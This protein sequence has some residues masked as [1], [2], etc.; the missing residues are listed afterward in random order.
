MPSNSANNKRIAKNTLLLY[1]RMAFLMIVSL[2]TSRVILQALGVEDFGIFNVVGGIISMFTILS[3]SLT[4]AITRFITFE[5]GKNNMERLKSVFATS[6]NIQLGIS[7]LI[8]LIA[9]VIGLWF[10]NHEMNIPAERIEA[11]NV[12]LH[13]SLGI[14]VFNLISVPYN[15][16]IIAHEQMGAYAYI[17]ILDILLKLVV[18]YA[19]NYSPIDCLS[20][21]ALLLLAEAAFIRMVYG[22]YSKRH[23][24]ECTYSFTHD[25]TVLKEM[26]KFAGWNFLG[27][28]AGTLNTQGVNILMNIYFNVSVNAARGIAVQ[29]GA[30]ITQFVHSFTTAVNPQITKSYAAGNSEYLFSLIC[31]SAKFST[32]LFLLIAIPLVVEAPA[33]FGLWLHT[34]PD[35]AVIFFRLSVLGILMDNVLV[36]PLITAIMATGDIKKYQVSVT[37][38]GALVFPL[39]WLSYHIGATPEWTYIIYFIIY[40]LVL[41]IRLRIV[42]EKVGLPIHRYASEVLLKVVPIGVIVYMAVAMIPFF[43]SQSIPR[44]IGTTLWSTLFSCSIIF[45]IGLNAG[46]KKLVGDKLQAVIGKISQIKESA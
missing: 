2:F 14:F 25:K 20:F 31:R 8:V 13:C 24:E 11:A 19:I 18:A 12:V 41:A 17:S 27:A 1:V 21:Y 33:I 10:L 40:C 36:N 6:V 43:F 46:E 34:V 42:K 5:L 39:T 16:A 3:G 45:L 26:T 38:V 4:N 29:A 44:V 35:H 32:Y 23:F 30:A 15:A 28:G 37:L 9:E 7:F 22:I